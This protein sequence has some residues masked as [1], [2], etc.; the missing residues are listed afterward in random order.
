M[1]LVMMILVRPDEERWRIAAA[2]SF[3]H[4]PSS[5]SSPHD[6]EQLMVLL[7]QKEEQPI[8]FSRLLDEHIATVDLYHPRKHAIRLVIV[9][10]AV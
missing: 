2:L 7:R 5:S 4:L 3:L 1:P 10:E 9:V 8:D 6:D